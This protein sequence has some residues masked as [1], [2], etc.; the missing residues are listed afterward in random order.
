MRGRRG[1]GGLG[2]GHP[3]TRLRPAD[4]GS[5]RVRFPI[6]GALGNPHQARGSVEDVPEVCQFRRVLDG[7]LITARSA[8]RGL[9]CLVS[10]G[11]PTS[12]LATSSS[13]R[14]CPSSSSGSARPLTGRSAVS[15]QAHGQARQRHQQDGRRCRNGTQY[16]LEVVREGAV[17][18]FLDP[19]GVVGGRKR[20]N[21]PDGGIGSDEVEGTHVVQDVRAD[22][23][24]TVQ[25]VAQGIRGNGADRIDRG[26]ARDTSR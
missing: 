21:E 20:R 18:A 26:R 6:G 11:A 7:D 5:R 17:E 1:L 22:V 15:A 8:L 13:P 23:S 3:S 14:P 9:Q 12:P 19:E 4:S 10:G 16:Q 24:G 2:R 25:V